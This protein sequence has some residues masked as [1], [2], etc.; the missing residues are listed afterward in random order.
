MTEEYGH[1]PDAFYLSQ[2]EIETLRKSKNYLTEYGKEKLRKLMNKEQSAT[3]EL[4][5]VDLESILECVTGYIHS[6]DE[7]YEKDFELQENIKTAANK[8]LNCYRDN[9]TD[10]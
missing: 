3:V 8:I 6:N 1:I 2:E 7:H 10:R 5:Q 4:T 9:F